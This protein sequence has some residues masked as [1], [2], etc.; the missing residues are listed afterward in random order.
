MTRTAARRKLFLDRFGARRVM[1]FALG[2][3]A[4]LGCGEDIV[5]R[6]R[7]PFNAPADAE[8]GFLGY[9]DVAARQTT[10]GNCHVD[11]QGEW[12]G[13]RHADA[14]ATLAAL[15]QAQEF[16]YGCHTVNGRGNVASGETVGH[17]AIA[18]PSY[19]DVQCE[20]CHGPGLEHVEGVGQGMLARPLARISMD[21]TGTC[22]DCHSGAHHPFAEEWAAS[23][24]ANVSVS[25]A[26]N[27]ASGCA[28]CHDGRKALEAWGVD[29]NYIERDLATGYQPTTC[30][31]CHDPHGSPNSA[32][33]R[34]SIE[35]QDPSQNLCIK[36]HARTSVPGPTATSPH[37]P[38]GPVLFGTAGYRPPGFVYDT[39]R[40]YG[41]HATTR[42][43]KLCAGCHIARFTVTDQLTGAFVF[44]ATGHLMRPIPCLDGDGKPTADKSCA[45]TETARSWQ[46]CTNSGCHADA[47][48]AAAAFNAVRTRMKGY[49]DQLWVDL[50]GNG[51]MQA[52]PSDTGLLPRVRQLR[53]AEW[54]NTDNTI[55]PAEGAEFNARLCGEYGQSTSDNSKG[56]HNP[57]LCE[58]LL[59]A[60]IDYIRS[61]Y[62]LTATSAAVDQALSAPRFGSYRHAPMPPAER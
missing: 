18:H 23:R 44:E 3:L 41:S 33:L 46:T 19:R 38:Q 16:C 55:T 24:H 11:Y 56:V 40:I 50:N 30:A 29:A 31:V 37:A 15:P 6:D 25:R 12:H 59:V 42:N 4:V 32:Q 60:T 54:S 48:R 27:V 47:G 14:Y 45:Y 10:C 35:S 8:S 62:E 26:S 34:F 21:G 9:Y 2:A 36:C 58:A 57:F 1:V 13:T 7:Q 49:T 5:Y 39:A 22:G 20:S 17:D 53:P 52:A 61:Y 51:S 43:P 28:A